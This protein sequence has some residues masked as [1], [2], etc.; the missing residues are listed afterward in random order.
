MK[1]YYLAVYMLIFILSLSFVC[2]EDNATIDNRNYFEVDEF[3]DL[4]AAVDTSGAEDTI[5]VINLTGD[6]QKE[7]IT[8]I[9]ISSNVTIN[10]NGHTIDANKNCRVFFIDYP[11]SLYLNN[12][13]ITNGYMEWQFKNM[14]ADAH[15]S[16]G[17]CIMNYGKLFIKDC[18]FTNNV[19]LNDGGVICCDDG[20]YTSISGTNVFSNNVAFNDAGVI[21]NGFRSVLNIT[22]KNTF[23]NN[24]A[25]KSE[26]GKAGAIL[27]AFDNAQLFISGE[28]VFSN[29]RATY[30]AGAIFNHQAYANITG[31]NIF[32]GNEANGKEGKGGAINNENG[33]LYLSGN[34][35]FKSNYAVRGGAIDNSLFEGRLTISGKNEF[36]EN[37]ATM[38]GALSNQESLYLNLYGENTFM[39][40][41]ATSIGGAIY[42][43]IG[44]LNISSKNTFSKNSAK[45]SGG[46]IYSA[47]NNA[48]I[49][50]E[51]TFT[52]NSAREGGAL[53]FIDSGNVGIVGN[54]KF[55]S[56]SATSAGGAIWARNVNNLIL[57]NHDY[58]TSNK[59][60]HSG[61]A[62]YVQ[63][64]T[65]DTKGALY[66]SNSAVYGGAI[67]LY[68]TSFA[69]QYNIFKN[70]AATGT[71]AD[72][73]SYLSSVHS[74][75]YNYWNSQNKVSQNN[76][77]G[78]D[79]SNIKSWTVLDFTIPSEIKQ[80]KNTEVARF[81]TNALT[82]L[83]GEMPD[84]TVGVTPNFNPSNVIITKNVAKSTYV[85]N[86]GKTSVNIASSNF[87][88]SKVVN[89]LDS[90]VRTSLA[91]NNVI[92]E[93]S[94]QK[95]NY[96][97]VLSDVNGNKLAGK[98]IVISV[99]GKNYTKKSDNL[100]KVT[101]ML[102]NLGNGYHE[103]VST[104][105]G[106]KNY[107]ESS[108][109][110]VI[111]FIFKSQRNIQLTADDVVMYYKDGT[112]Y[113]LTLT[114]ADNYPLSSKT[115]KIYIN[116]LI[117]S[118]T[119]DK[120]GKASIAINLNSGI[121]NILAYYCT[122]NDDF[123]VVNN[124]IEVRSTISGDNLVKHFKNATQYYAKF[125]NSKGNPLKNTA[126]SFNINGVSYQRKTN[127]SGYAKLNINLGPGTYIITATNPVNNEQ[128]TNNI[129]VL[130]T[131]EA[132]DLIKYYRN[133]SQYVIKV[134]G[135]NGKSVGKGKV[136]RFN[137]NGV[138]YERMTNESGYAKLNINLEPGTY[139]ITAQY[140]DLFHSNTIKVKP[141]LYGKDIN[142]KYMD[143]TK[144][145]VT[146]VNKQGKVVP[147]ASISLNIN[148]VFYD[149]LTDNNGVARLNIRLM[150][151]KYIITATYFD[152]I[153][154]NKITIS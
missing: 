128:H 111:F 82:D 68:E 142:M 41:K 103:I 145:E 123:A 27:N 79:I 116:G 109:T 110:N 102:N 37:T 61:G 18:T 39:S 101:L 53:L 34:N 64:S 100:G 95:A 134:L 124:T 154:S 92:L 131:L 153:T 73:E 31:T 148:G 144:Y 78:Y 74:L 49:A 105:S 146:L 141:T 45:N 85:G 86:P 13:T 11:G 59:A 38:G 9:T 122:E 20:A 114:D 106:D 21:T 67:Y 29:N 120:D 6:I 151:G 32:T 150:P 56:N 129:T 17:G 42:S 152:A 4:V 149:R 26:Y 132:N 121:S 89:V 76:I 65:L 54:N 25:V 12:L 63:S 2:A 98:T 135:D 46:A 72:I 83:K 140:G 139:V 87:K 112:K 60:S 47:N 40:N 118:R 35:T 138:F 75:E 136:V 14:P 23:D 147:N 108:T 44:I 88:Q 93:N 48:F 71:G 69:G 36:I 22:G 113:E 55:N 52:A 77:H 10:G 99:D 50:G 84:Y 24:T 115:I 125:I 117:Y 62:V 119:T 8:D 127:E 7:V 51:N 104:Y 28:N 57:G 137:I 130:S 16:N 33:T 15:Y 126:V 107:Y 81:K 58:F 1:K 133:D 97:V 43:Y 30:D 70:N 5:C 90:R 96:E 19:A 3:W 91:G 80:Y 143:G 66:E 94:S